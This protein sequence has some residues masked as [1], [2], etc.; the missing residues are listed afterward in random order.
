[1]PGR[2]EQLENEF[3]RQVA[4][5]QTE[6]KKPEVKTDPKKLE[7]RMDGDNP[8]LA[9]RSSKVNKLQCKIFYR[10]SNGI[11]Y[12][13]VVVPEKTRRKSLDSSVYIE[14]IDTKAIRRKTFFLG[15]IMTVK[16]TETLF[17]VSQ[18]AIGF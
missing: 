14:L 10:K 13:N 15:D 18:E 7:R 3:R 2:L 16:L 4:A 1:M 17:P 9:L 5:N 12:R 6:V 11:V 8:R